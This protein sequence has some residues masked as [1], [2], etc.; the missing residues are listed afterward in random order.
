[1]TRGDRHTSRQ[2]RCY[3]SQVPEGKEFE[4]CGV[5]GRTILRGERVAEY[6][7]PDG[8]RMGVCS[9]CKPAAELAGWVPADL[10]RAPGHSAAAGRRGL[11]LRKRLSRA[12]EAARSLA[13]RP[14]REQDPP[15]QE[16]RTGDS[17][18]PSGRESGA[19]RSRRGERPQ[20]GKDERSGKGERSGSHPRSKQRSPSPQPPSPARLLRTGLERFN[21]SAEPRKV[22]G[23]IRTLGEPRV[24]VRVNRGGPVVVTVAW[25]LSWYQWEVGADSNGDAVREAGKGNEVSELALRD[26]NWNASAASDGTVTLKLAAAQQ[27][28]GERE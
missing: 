2:R 21:A 11:G 8:A 24:A 12:S 18:P 17:Q 23:L 4:S 15:A 5:C 26:R 28:S 19:D 6:V 22:A 9:L 27:D 10:A 20:N 1:V 3:V 25:E 7:A 16:T 13:P 14:A